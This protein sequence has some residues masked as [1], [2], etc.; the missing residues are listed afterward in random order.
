LSTLHNWL[1]L[2]FAEH[3]FATVIYYSVIAKFWWN[4]LWSYYYLLLQVI[5]S[6][7]STN[8][9]LQS[10]L[11]DPTVLMQSCW[12]LSLCTAHSF[13]SV[14]HKYTNFNIYAV[15]SSAYL[16]RVME[17]LMRG[18]NLLS[19]NT[20]SYQLCSHTLVVG[21]NCHCCLYTHQCLCEY[22]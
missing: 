7:F 15:T 3:A 4:I 20:W 16:H 13:V 1:Q 11:N 10:Q 22:T 6:A 18:D 14:E 2:W 21:C 12:Q 19:R 8:P 5:P 9:G 17:M